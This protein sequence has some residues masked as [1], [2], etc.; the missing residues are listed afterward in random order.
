[1]TKKEEDEKSNDISTLNIS[2]DKKKIHQL[3]FN[4]NI[5]YSDIFDQ[6]YIFLPILKKKSDFCYTKNF[7][8]EKMETDR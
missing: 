2:F 5:S 6:K 4:K 7:F 3:F 1:M 8:Y